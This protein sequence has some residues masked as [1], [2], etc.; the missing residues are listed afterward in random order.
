MND[1]L[2][3]VH[4]PLVVAARWTGVTPAALVGAASTGGLWGMPSPA[5]RG[6]SCTATDASPI[7]GA[8]GASAGS[9]VIIKPRRKAY[10]THEH[11]RRPTELYRTQRTGDGTN[12]PTPAHTG[13]VRGGAARGAARAWRH[14]GA[15]GAGTLSLSYPARCSA[16]RPRGRCP[17]GQP[18]RQR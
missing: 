14:A 6:G 9:P 12:G 10:E 4:C 13:R 18:E 11:V 3:S 16:P 15:P 2:I 7:R 5:G 17:G 8:G 1:P